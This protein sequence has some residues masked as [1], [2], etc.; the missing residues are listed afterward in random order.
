MWPLIMTWCPDKGAVN[1]RDL[2][3]TVLHPEVVQR[4]S[5]PWGHVA[6]LWLLSLT[7]NDALDATAAFGRLRVGN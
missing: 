3:P 1:N 6:V 7:E 2:L 4:A 5:T